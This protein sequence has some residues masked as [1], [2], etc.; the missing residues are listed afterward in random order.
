MARD[1]HGETHAQYAFALTRA[2]RAHLAVG[3]VQAAE[4]AF[5]SA[6]AVAA[7]AAGDHQRLDLAIDSAQS[8]LW[9]LTGDFERMR[10]AQLDRFAGTPAP[11]S[12]AAAL[13]LASLACRRAPAPECDASLAGEAERVLADPSCANNFQCLPARLALAEI[14]WLDGAP[15]PAIAAAEDALSEGEAELGAGHSM[16]VQ[17]HLLLAAMH[18]EAGATDASSRHADQANDGLAQLP[19]GHP[20]HARRGMYARRP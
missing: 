8:R 13:A 15:E 5:T 12:R 3:D 17:M 7:S 14:A 11:P 4:A 6:R 1:V 18:A 16:I 19:P 20:L 2:A 10:A 9:W